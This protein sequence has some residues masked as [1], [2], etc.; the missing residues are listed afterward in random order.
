MKDQRNVM[1]LVLVYLIY[2]KTDSK[3]LNIKC[4][5]KSIF[6][7]ESQIYEIKLGSFI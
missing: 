5:P 3:L 1:I 2:D 6:D 7:K 4:N